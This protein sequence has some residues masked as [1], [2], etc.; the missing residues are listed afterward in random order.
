MAGEPSIRVF[1]VMLTPGGAEK[2]STLLKQVLKIRGDRAVT[3][4][5]AA[6][7]M[8]EKWIHVKT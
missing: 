1:R 6:R 7:K 5:R 8:T 3:V 2:S 4:T